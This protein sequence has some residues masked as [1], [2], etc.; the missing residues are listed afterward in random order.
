M[1]SRGGAELPLQ[2]EM[3]LAICRWKAVILDDEIRKPSAGQITLPQI[4]GVRSFIHFALFVLCV[5][6]GFVR[7]PRV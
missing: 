3:H 4:S 1:I 7:K 2:R 5:Y 6:L